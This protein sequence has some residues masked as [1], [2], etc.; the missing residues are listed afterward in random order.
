M[1]S[2]VEILKE[3]LD[4]YAK[5]WENTYAI[6]KYLDK[7]LNA[8]LSS[9]EKQTIQKA[10]GDKDSK[11]F[12]K[13]ISRNFDI[14]FSE[15]VQNIS[16]KIIQDIIIPYTKAQVSNTKWTKWTHRVEILLSNKIVIDLE[17]NKYPSFNLDYINIKLGEF[18]KHGNKQYDLNTITEKLN[19]YSFRKNYGDLYAPFRFKF[20]DE[21]NEISTLLNKDKIA[22][23]TQLHEQNIGEKLRQIIQICEKI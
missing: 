13:E 4:N 17:Y 23:L 14:I 1:K 5:K 8:S 10:I 3:Y 18:K 11:K 20:I 16:S 22:Q 15:K 7:D 12:A 19:S 21:K 6:F 2:E 9:P